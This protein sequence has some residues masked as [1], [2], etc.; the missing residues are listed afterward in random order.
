MDTVF[1]NGK[2]LPKGDAYVSVEDRGFLFGDAVYEVIPIYAGVPFR[3]EAH[4]RRLAHS[5]DSL[6]IDFDP[7]E[8]GPMLGQLVERNGL[9]D[10]PTSMVYLQVTRGVAPR[11]HHFPPDGTRPTVFAFAAPFRRP[12]G[13]VWDQGFGAITTPDRRWA[14]VDLKTV[15]LLPNVLAQEAAREAGASDAILVRD[16]IALEAGHSNLWVVFG[17]T[18]RTHPTSH[19]ILSGITRELVL[20]LA[21]G[22][23]YEVEERATPVEAL[24]T[25]SEVFVTGSLTEIRPIV[26]IDGHPVGEGKVGP[27]SRDLYRAFLDAVSPERGVRAHATA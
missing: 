12:E 1:L 9:A 5:L 8:V 3:L 11:S 25:A 13:S 27:V 22:C 7:E 23:G 18:V 21:R 16:G 17:R 19:Q 2:Y 10:V 24:R 14:R 26:R 15:Q 6:R 20:E 4:K